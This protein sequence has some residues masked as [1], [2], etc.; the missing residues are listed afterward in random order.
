M[1]NSKKSIRDV[2][3]DAYTN[4]L[5]EKLEEVKFLIRAKGMKD[6]NSYRQ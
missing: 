1:D 2:A 6:T 5:L 3:P 4:Y